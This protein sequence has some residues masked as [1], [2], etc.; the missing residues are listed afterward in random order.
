MRV[1][2]AVLAASFFLLAVTPAATLAQGPLEV[3][4][5]FPAVVADPGASADFD[6]TVTTDT[7]QRVDLTVTQQP[8]GWTTNL[9][10]GGSTVSAVFTGPTVDT[11]T[12]N[13]AVV[14]AEVQVPEDAAAGSN[15]VVI[16]GRTSSGTTVTLTLDI[17][18]EIQEA[19][20]VTLQ[21]DNPDLVGTADDSFTF[22]VEIRN[23][24]NQQVTLSFETDGPAGWRVEASPGGD[25]QAATAVIDAGG[26]GSVEVAVTPTVDAAAQV[27]PIVLRAVGGPQPV[28]IPLTVEITGSFAMSMSTSDDRLSSNVTA[29]GTTQLTVVVV[30]EGS[31]PLEAV[32]LTATAPRNWTVTFD[33]ETVAAIAPLQQQEVPVTIQAAGDAVAGDYVVTLRARN[34]EVNDS[35][36]IRT[37]VETSPIGGLLGIGVLVLVGVG[38]FFVFQ[39]YG[40]R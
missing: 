15:Q 22:P 3:T 2:R 17:T 19:G 5:P 10:G 38:L 16:E 34:D 30:N 9:R 6:V 29:G 37:T 1:L 35:I 20:A 36:E 12:L 24:G 31:A 14:T 27:Y 18:I 25:S 7:P 28:E 26:L 11:P 39:R 40:R 4:T 8:D 23:T 21:S 32:E 13:T 33:P